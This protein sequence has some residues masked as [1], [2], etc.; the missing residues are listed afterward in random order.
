MTEKIKLSLDLVNESDCADLSVELLVNGQSFYNDKVIPGTHSLSHEV[1]LEEGEHTFSIVLSGKNTE[2][3]KVNEMGQI[4]SD[5]LIKATNVCFDDINIDQ[6]MSEQAV[7]T[8]NNNDTAELTEHKFYG[9]MGCNGT[10]TLNF[11]SPF[12]LWLLEHM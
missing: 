3:T 5:V 7:Y 9:P 2:H 6:L 4:I 12:Y 8:H 10:V 11:T 1:D